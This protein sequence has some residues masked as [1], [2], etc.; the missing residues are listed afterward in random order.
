VA[1]LTRLSAPTQ[2]EPLLV[3]GEEVTSATTFD[4]RDKYTDEI[5]A[6]VAKAER[7]HVAAAVAGGV[8]AARS[9]ALPPYQ[10]FEILSRASE[11]VR[12]QR[13]MLRDTI[14][15][16][17]G[18]PLADATTEVDRTSQTLLLCAEEAKRI[19]GEMV[20]IEGA[21]N[22]SHRL[23]FTMR[24]PIGVVCAITPFNSPLN[25]VAHKIGPAIA[26][27]N[28]VVL[29]PSALTPLS[30]GRLC[31]I[32]LEAGLPREYLSLINGPGATCG[33]WLFDEADVAFYT[34]T[35]STEVG[36]A[37]QAGAGLR[38]TQLE[39]GSIA[40]TVVCG[41]ADL[42]WA[43]AR[44]VPAAFR[45]AGQVCT[46]IQ[47]LYVERDVVADFTDRFVAA[48]KATHAGDP[49]DPQ[50]VVG[51]MISA[52]EARRAE[53]WVREAVS[54]GARCLVGGHRDGPVLWPTVLCDVPPDA[55]L[56]RQ[57]A[58]APLVAIMPFDRFEDALEDLNA[59]PYGLSAGVFTS[60][61]DRGLSAA[62]TLRVG[63]VHINETSSGRSDLV[64]YG[65]H[66]DSGHGQEGPRYA[67]RE[68]TEERLVTITTLPGAEAGG[69]VR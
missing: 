46:S 34:F 6:V 30:A 33:S 67:I 27:G 37:V 53:L 40:G 38:R 26:A 29:K 12:E 17:A 42:G 35:G 52:E 66:K 69:H 19:T 2:R 41:D 59:T 60:D 61:I 20:P 31:R 13:E 16:E 43:V 22:Q 62:R 63:S 4:V 56:M 24:F 39:L 57:E 44:C 32:L 11:L 3:A 50:T 65:G 28:A 14:V 64:P 36:R 7:S 48:A 18:F 21:P 58:F 47:R 25:T 5:I 51:P 1:A 55:T 54:Q 10:R 68:L 15:A 9:G 49:R 23:A 45:K 8:A